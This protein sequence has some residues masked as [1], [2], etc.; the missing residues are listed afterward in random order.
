MEAARAC[1]VAIVCVGDLAGLF[2]SG[3]V[4]E[5]SDTDTLDLP[6]EQQLL[7]AVVATGTPTVVVLHS[8][9]PYS[10]GGLED[11]VAAH[12]LAHAGRQQGGTAIAQVLAGGRRVQR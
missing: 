4:G 6:G 8:G 5:G 7:A 1:D 2:Q 10:L 12:V 3:T 9:R 11:R